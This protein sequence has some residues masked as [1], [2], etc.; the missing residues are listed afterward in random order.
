MRT[1]TNH[2]PTTHTSFILLNL[3]QHWYLDKIVYKVQPINLNNTVGIWILTIW[4]PETFEHWNF[5]SSDFKW[6]SIQ[7]VGQSL[8]TIPTIWI[9]DQ[10]IR[11]KDV[12][13]LSDIQMVGL[14]SIQIA[15]KNRT[16]WDLTSFWPFEYQTILV[17][18]SPL[19]FF[20]EIFTSLFVCALIIW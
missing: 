10:Y 16:I 18:R 6:F 1:H 14:S 4:I 9:P 11:N 3:T 17:F 7:M 5:W 8:C 2:P 12:I 20:D 19:W 13:P 15:F